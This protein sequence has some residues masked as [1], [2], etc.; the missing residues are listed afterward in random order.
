M[1]E[2]TLKLH[3]LNNMSQAMWMYD[4]FEEPGPT[5]VVRMGRDHPDNYWILVQTSDPGR[6]LEFL[7]SLDGVTEAYS[8]SPVQGPA[9]PRSINVTLSPFV[10][11][12][13]G[14]QPH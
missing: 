5:S 9:I 14:S 13:Q 6:L 1:S 2:I 4:Q 12:K 7:R 11:I 8:E 3:P 10:D